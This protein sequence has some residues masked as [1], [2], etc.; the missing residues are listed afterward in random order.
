MRRS[1]SPARSAPPPTSRRTCT[2]ARAAPTGPSPSTSSQ[3]ALPNA[4]AVSLVVG[5]FGTDLRAGHCEIRPGVDAAD[6]ITEPLTWSVAG[7]ARD[8]AHLVSLVDGRAAY[9]GTPS[10]QTV[11]R[12]HPGSRRPA[13][14]TSPS[15]PS[16][17][18]TCRPATRSPIPTPAPRASRAYPWRGRI[19]VSP[20]PGQPGTPDKTG[21][22]ATQV[23]AFVGTADVADFAIA[24]ES[25]TYSGP[26]RVVA[27]AASILHYAHLAAA[28]GGV[29]AFVIGTELRGLT[30][31]RD[32]ASTY[33]FVA[34]L[35]DLAADVKSVLGPAPKSPTPPTGRN[36]SATSRADG[37]GDVYFH[38]D[39]LWS[40]AAI[41]AIGIDVY[42]PLAD[43]RDGSAHADRLAGAAS[44]YDLDYL[45]RQSRRRRG[46]RLVL[47]QRRRPRR[48]GAQRNHRRRRRQA[49][50]VPLQGHPQL[51]AQ[52]ALQS[53]RRHRSPARP[54]PG[55]RS[56]SRSGSWSSAAPPS[57]RA[58][59]SPTSSSIPKSSEIAPA[60]LLPRQARRLHAAPLPAG[61]PRGPRSRRTR[62]TSPAPIPVS[63]RLRRPHGRS[64]PHARLRLGRAALSR[65]PRRHQCLGR[66]PQLAARPLAHRAHLQRAAGRDRARHP[67][68]PR[69]RRPRRRQPQR[70]RSAACSSIA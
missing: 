17:S 3:P 34:A 53:P 4:G 69:L 39:P 59:T 57:T 32:S 1:P 37:S 8:D 19:T 21:A 7:L 67:R 11:D 35:V 5:W 2:R 63:D 16:S 25:V 33:P 13:A 52:P 27:S 30:T 36:T 54:P 31:V 43:W 65:L 29:D 15:R 10:D 38:L 40:R 46:L 49:L 56:P 9:G 6:K 22:A 18:W 26:D 70:H 61:V 55:C 48:A 12:R 14:S 51:V 64:R 45:A 24:G 47:R 23:A 58:P 68:R 42:W 28:A 44:I 62:T 50:G 20:A 41:D 66:R 60:L